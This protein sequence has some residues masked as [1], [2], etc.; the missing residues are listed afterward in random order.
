MVMKT[1]RHSVASEGELA[2]AGKANPLQEWQVAAHVLVDLYDPSRKG[3]AFLYLLRDGLAW[4]DPDLRH[5]ERH[6]GVHQIWAPDSTL[7]SLWLVPHEMV[8]KTQKHLVGS[9]RELS[10]AGK[11]N[12]LQK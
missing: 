6:G 11:T 4:M 5:S 2:G 7:S 12:L 8:M 9:E 10:G 1:Q 3:K